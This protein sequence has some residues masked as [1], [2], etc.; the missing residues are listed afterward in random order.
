MGSVV[1][2]FYLEF[3]L[4]YICMVLDVVPGVARVFWYDKHM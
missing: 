1:N 2:Q 3:Y 4:Q